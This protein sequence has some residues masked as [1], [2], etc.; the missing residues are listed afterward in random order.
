M[1][2]L[3]KRS[4]SRFTPL[5][6]IQRYTVIDAVKV[7]FYGVPTIMSTNELLTEEQVNPLFAELKRKRTERRKEWLR[8]R[9]WRRQSAIRLAL[10]AGITTSQ[11]LARELGI[12]RRSAAQRLRWTRENMRVMESQS[13]PQSST[14]DV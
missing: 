10:K 5:E 7:R 4:G 2:W 6:V 11:A 8:L 14:I 9:V 1:E 13:P 12:T 3:Y